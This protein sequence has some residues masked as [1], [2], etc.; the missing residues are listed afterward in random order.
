MEELFALGY[1]TIVTYW[2]RGVKILRHAR[3]MPRRL[4]ASSS[5]RTGDP[6][7]LNVFSR[8]GYRGQRA[9]RPKS[10]GWPSGEYGSASPHPNAK[11]FSVP[12][13]AL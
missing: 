4:T 13:R 3:D 11:R 2:E 5:F 6:V 9:S 8:H 7:R 12:P 1:V 10:G